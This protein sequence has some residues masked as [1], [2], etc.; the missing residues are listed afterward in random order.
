MF[1]TWNERQGN[2][3]TLKDVCSVKYNNGKRIQEVVDNE[4]LAV[5]VLHELTHS[6]SAVKDS[7]IDPDEGT[8]VS[9]IDDQKCPTNPNAGAYGWLCVIQLADHPE[10]AVRNADSYAIFAAAVYCNKNN[11]ATGVAHPVS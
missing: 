5:A 1:P 4:H 7:V 2:G 11:W 3:Q 10:L 8:E 6:V 9:P